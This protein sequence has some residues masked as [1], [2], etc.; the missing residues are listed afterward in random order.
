MKHL[1]ELQ[2]IEK[3]LNESTTELDKLVAFKETDTYE[4]SAYTYAKSGITL[5]K[6]AIIELSERVKVLEAQ[7][8]AGEES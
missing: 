4:A 5:L 2:S 3:L 6:Q 7:Q 8:F 1:R